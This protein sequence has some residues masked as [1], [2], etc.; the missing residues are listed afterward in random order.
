[1]NLKKLKPLGHLAVFA[2]ALAVTTATAQATTWYLLRDQATNENYNT[3][4]LWNSNSAGT[5]TVATAM[6]VNATYDTNGKLLRTVNV[7]TGATPFS[8]GPLVLNQSQLLLK[9]LTTV[10]ANLSTAAT[11]A[12]I[13][14]GSPDTNFALHVTGTF[15]LNGTTG[16][17]SQ[18]QRTIA[19]EAGALTGTGNLL[20][21][22]NRQITTTAA[23]VSAVTL[24]VTDALTYTGSIIVAATTSTVSSITYTTSLSFASDFHSGG[25]L[26][27]TTGG[28]LNL[29]NNLSFA[30]GLFLD[31]QPVTLS[32]GTYDYATLIAANASLAGV[33]SDQGGHLIVGSIPEPSTFATLAGFS[34]LL[35]GLMVRRRSR[36]EPIVG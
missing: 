12:D 8:G 21:G 27:L 13:V 35:L 14:N 18:T 32:D 23:T 5:G 33:F 34:V 22:G 3:P 24:N 17:F 36:A 31:N 30:G 9:Q 29:A 28:T 2:T 7:T 6:D 25:A 15:A 4:A 20:I 11:G 1:M 10:V 16:I 19:L 26:K